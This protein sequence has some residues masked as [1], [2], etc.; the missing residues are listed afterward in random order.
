MF[1]K[2]GKPDRRRTRNPRAEFALR[3]DMITQEEYDAVMLGN[4]TLDDRQIFNLNANL[5]WLKTGEKTAIYQGRASDL[6]I[7][8]LLDLPFERN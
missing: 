5:P 7:N 3:F 4:A 8:L 1:R 2:T 6:K